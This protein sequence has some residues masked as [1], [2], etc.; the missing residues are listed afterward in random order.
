MPEIV[1]WRSLSAAYSG[2]RALVTGGL[3][4]LGSNLTIALVELG[5]QVTVVDI[6]L[7]DAGG[8]TYNIQGVRDVVNAH[9]ADVRDR[10]V[11][12]ELVR[13]QDVIFHLAAHTSHIDSLNT[14]LIDLDI[15]CAGTLVLL[16]ACR[17]NNP[18]VRLIYAGTRAQ[19]GAPSVIPVPEDALCKPLDIYA[20]NKL[21]GEHYCLLYGRM[22]GLKVTSLRLSNAY[23]PRHQ[24]QHCKFGVLNWFIRLALDGET[25]SVFG[26]GL[27]L[28]DYNYVRDVVDAFLLT[29]LSDNAVGQVFNLGSGQPRSLLEIVQL[30]IKTAGSGEYELAPWPEERARIDVGDFVADF[31]K[32]QHLLGWM[33]MVSMEE[34]LQ[35]TVQFYREHQQHYWD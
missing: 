6:L 3:G 22:H 7:P 17:H 19:Y 15:N 24:M 12:D 2:K 5:A 13:G 14:P 32:I 20:I 27:Q 33:P 25:I 26:N 9:F 10:E 8:N 16:E 1:Q 18:G 34:G 11:M 28:R 4:F 30:V 21:A 23:G 31:S 35:E 29:G